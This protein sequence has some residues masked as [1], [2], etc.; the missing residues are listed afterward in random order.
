MSSIEI[1]LRVGSVAVYKVSS[2]PPAD[3]AVLDSIKIYHILQG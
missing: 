3:H 1:G 2:P